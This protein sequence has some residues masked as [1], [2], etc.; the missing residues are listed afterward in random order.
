MMDNDVH[1]IFGINLL[2]FLSYQFET[3]NVIDL[4]L[5]LSEDLLNT[6][7]KDR[8]LPGYKVISLLRL[9]SFGFTST[10]KIEMQVHYICFL[11]LKVMECV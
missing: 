6:K 5:A 7:Y 1:S 9:P 4:S 10:M 11:L 3:D 2:I 8:L